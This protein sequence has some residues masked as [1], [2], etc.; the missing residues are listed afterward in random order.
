MP[1]RRDRPSW[2]W[3]RSILIATVCLTAGSFPVAAGASEVIHVD[4]DSGDVDRG[5]LLYQEG[6]SA[7]GAP[8]TAVLA[9]GSVEVPAA[10]VPCA[11]CHGRD[12]RGRPEGGVVPSNLTWQ[13]LTKPYGVQHASGRQ[14]PPYD[15]RSLVKA[16]SLGSDPAG[17]ALHAAMPRY[18]LSHRA[19][20]DLIAYLRVIANERDPGIGAETLRIATL[21]PSD[22]PAGEVGRSVV[23]TL[24]ALFADANAEGGVY[25]HR[26]VL[27][28]LALPAADADLASRLAGAD[29]FGLAAPL[30]PGRDAALAALSREAQ[31]PVIGP[32]T[33]EPQTGFPPNRQVF[34]LYSG[35]AGQAEALLAFAVDQHPKLR[36]LAIAGGTEAV[37]Q[38]VEA[39]ARQRFSEPSLQIATSV[40]T[41]DGDTLVRGWIAAETEAVLWLDAGIEPLLHAAARHGWSGAIYIPGALVTGAAL[42]A[43]A[44]SGCQLFLASPHPTGSAAAAG[45]NNVL[46]WAAAHHLPAKHRA[47]MAATIAAG[48]LL[49][50]GLRSA[51]RDLSRARLVEALETIRQLD[52][53]TAPPLSYSPNRRVGIHGAAILAFDPATGGLRP[54]RGWQPLDNDR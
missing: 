9:G 10:T 3:R 22:G 52:T 46:A 41:E 16:I 14:H 11:S 4:V 34:Y 47:V 21:T 45:R 18:R 32:I 1:V 15:E 53:G 30:A 13:S 26:L 6:E 36:R 42:D 39:A 49:V 29:I 25:G 37:A 20:D 44:S 5:R 40:E 33:L 28:P 27:V 24:R 17:N 51:G 38:A 48:R 54:V 7:D 35:L 19:M 23:A 2:R 12:G 31:L 50:E 8:A 43:V